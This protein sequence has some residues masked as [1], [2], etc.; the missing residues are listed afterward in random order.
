[1]GKSFLENLLRNGILQLLQWNILAIF[2]NLP[3]IQINCDN[4]V[5]RLK[6]FVNTSY[7]DI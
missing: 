1:M 2:K 6:S 7:V 4:P 5:I 3:E